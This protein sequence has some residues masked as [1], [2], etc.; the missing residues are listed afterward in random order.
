[1]PLP[2]R[3]PRIYLDIHIFI[4][5]P[6]CSCPPENQNQA[7]LTGKLICPSKK[8]IPYFLDPILCG[9]LLCGGSLCTAEGLTLP[10]I[11]EPLRKMR[12][13]F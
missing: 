8:N 10:T 4:P 6:S 12:C 1:V 2:C 11:E 9:T 3:A 13:I 5:I 7:K